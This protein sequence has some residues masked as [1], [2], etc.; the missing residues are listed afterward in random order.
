L[1]EL[2]ALGLA[3]RAELPF[4]GYITEGRALV[5]IDAQPVEPF[6]HGIGEFVAAPF[7]I[8]VFQ[9]EDEGAAVMTG[10]KPIE[11]GD[12]GGAD[13]E[14]ARWRRGDAHADSA[15]E[16]YAPQGLG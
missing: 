9:A 10:K 13:V 7:R 14:K 12:F 15:H 3:V 4:F 6:A 5:P 2:L 11:H 16:T 1:V 8:G